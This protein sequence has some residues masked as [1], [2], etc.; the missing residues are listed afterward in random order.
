MKLKFGKEGHKLRLV[1]VEKFDEL[2][3]LKLRCQVPIKGYH[4]PLIKS[5]T[6]YK[7]NK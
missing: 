5:K 4:I 2:F 3:F 7:Y 6:Y 1:A